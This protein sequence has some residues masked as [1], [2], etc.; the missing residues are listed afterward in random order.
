MATIDPRNKTPGVD[1]S[2]INGG[3]TDRVIEL[4]GLVNQATG[5]A[6]AGT[7]T[8]NL[9]GLDAAAILNSYTL[10]ADPN[11]DTPYQD[12][13]QYYYQSSS[14]RLTQVQGIINKN[15]TDL[16]NNLTGNIHGLFDILNAKGQ[17]LNPLTTQLQ[18]LSSA[19]EIEA[20]GANLEAQ[21]NT[22]LTSDAAL[23]DIM[24]Q[25]FNQLSITVEK[26][27]KEVFDLLN[28]YDSDY[29]N[30][31]TDSPK[32]LLMQSGQD[33]QV[34]DSIDELY[35]V[36]I[37]QAQE[38]FAT[39][40]PGATFYE[41]GFIGNSI[42]TLY[43]HRSLKLS[44]EF[45]KYIVD[46]T[47]TRAAESKLH[48]SV[49]FLNKLS[50]D[51]LIR[52]ADD[53]YLTSGTDTLKNLFK[54]NL[55]ISTPKYIEDERSL[56]DLLQGKTDAA[57]TSNLDSTLFQSIDDTLQ[58]FNYSTVEIMHL[59]YSH[60]A[61]NKLQQTIRK[62]PTATIAYLLNKRASASPEDQEDID[63]SI[64]ALST[65]ETI[66]AG[67]EASSG[68][69]YHSDEPLDDSLSLD[70]VLNSI[71]VD[72]GL[73]SPHKLL[74]AAEMQEAG[75]I[76]ARS[77][78]Q[79]LATPMEDG[80]VSEETKTI[81]PWASPTIFSAV[82]AKIGSTL[83]EKITN[84]QPAST[85]DWMTQFTGTITNIGTKVNSGEFS[86]AGQGFI[87]TLKNN[88]KGVVNSFYGQHA[89]LKEEVNDAKT[90]LD[91]V[92][93]DPLNAVNILLEHNF[94]LAEG[95]LPDVFAADLYKNKLL[96]YSNAI[97]NF[98]ADGDNNG[99]ADIEEQLKETITSSG[100][101]IDGNGKNDFLD[102]KGITGNIDSLTEQLTGIFGT[103]EVRSGGIENQSIKRLILLMFVLNIMEPTDWDF[104]TND[105][106]TSRY[107]VS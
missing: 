40:H 86:S 5:Q 12:E 82:I 94:T 79:K 95:V 34:I 7:L 102:L 32:Y 20:V 75:V 33:T 19:A 8:I 36:T 93:N 53:F 73:S 23:N 81:P 83:I 10:G 39:A 51:R 47:L 105:A 44:P 52:L 15:L 99:I 30:G 96:E 100:L 66:L 11:S 92:I 50:L 63:A 3:I 72:T 41:D 80:E 62:N 78:G 89:A 64:I 84:L 31:S 25:F 87:D 22:N 77:F 21:L 85:Q 49:D 28:D 67:Y 57:D 27:N 38:T 69:Q 29:A 17:N 4:L 98:S 24:T 71:D 76:N 45:M 97:T 43:Y 56:F 101:D 18:G 107:E 104:A 106:D 14:Q 59:G 60:A 37:D 88:F 2:T 1:I 103:N 74:F 42:T 58:G 61:K 16:E 48:G 54:D 55:D 91:S 70:T 6:G 68:T 13:E 90:L 35:D 46:Q 65:R 26:I 9:D